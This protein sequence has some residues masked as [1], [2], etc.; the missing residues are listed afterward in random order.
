MKIGLFLNAKPTDGGAFQYSCSILHALSSINTTQFFVIIIYTNRHW[1]GPVSETGLTSFYLPAGIWTFLAR[2]RIGRH[3]PLAW[4]RRLCTFF[5][6]TVKT[7]SQHDCDLW[8]YPNQDTWTY[9]CPFPAL[10]TVYDL[11]HRYEKQF[12]E[13]SAKGIYDSRERH[14][15]NLCQFSKA[16]LVDSNL[17]KKQVVE[18]YKISPGK[19]FILPFVAATRRSKDITNET[20]KIVVLSSILCKMFIGQFFEERQAFMHFSDRG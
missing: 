19:V 11:M 8:I 13:V 15:T 4:W 18:S 5:H 1:I 17:G 16:I 14:Y 10:G 2:K 20:S 9:L 6:P 3:I 12:P 7:M